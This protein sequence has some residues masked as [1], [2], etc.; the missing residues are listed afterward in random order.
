MKTS[1][2]IKVLFVGGLNDVIQFE[3]LLTEAFIGARAI[4][5]LFHFILTASKF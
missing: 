3:G 5:P 1:T 2:W 4:V